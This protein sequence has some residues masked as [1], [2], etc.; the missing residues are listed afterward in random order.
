MMLSL[1][2]LMG[3]AALSI[4]FG[5]V[6]VAD[7]Q[8][9]NVA[10]AAALAAAAE[11]RAGPYDDDIKAAAVAVAHQN[12]VL[13]NDVDLS[14]DDVEIGF[15]DPDT[16]EFALGWSR[17]EPPVVRVTV[18]R[19]A[20]SDDGAIP[21]SFSRLF[22]VDEIPLT[23]TAM[24]GLT[25]VVHPR[26]A[27]EIV[28]V[29]DCSGSFQQEIECAK[30]A[31]R[32][33]VNL[34]DENCVDGDKMGAVGFNTEAYILTQTEAEIPPRPP[35]WPWWWPWPP[36]WWD[37]PEPSGLP[38]CEIPDDTDNELAGIDRVGNDIAVE[39][40]T[41][42]ELGIAEAH[43]ILNEEGDADNC[44][45]VIVLVSDGMPNPPSHRELTV[46]A[47]DEAAA[48]G[49]VIHTVTYDE[50]SG[51][52]DYGSRG[53]DAEFNA[54][55]V[56]NGGYSFHTPDADELSAILTAVGVIEIGHPV[57]LQ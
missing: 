54:S 45:Q 12:A 57:L 27:V 34:V 51:A 55:L 49:I 44:E 31:D 8:L 9:Q 26:R 56:R 40:Y 5:K 13:G 10:D 22:G 53:S 7:Q 43:S 29:Q 50:D 48:D 14:A 19:T 6:Y 3:M 16:N 37:P 2:A 35:W 17:R 1:L 28:I 47:C 52:S 33:L 46:E 24:A 4:D 25:A 23:A 32:T 39:G 30:D 18:H 38:L 11:A 15:I 36:S 20:T 41:Y 42:T 21:M